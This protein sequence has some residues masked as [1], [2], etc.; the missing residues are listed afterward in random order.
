MG[1][2]ELV[3]QARLAHA[4]LAHERHHLPVPG[5]GALQDVAQLVDFGVAADEAREPPRRGCLES[6]PRRPRSHE[7]VDLDLLPQPFDGR[8]A[9]RVDLHVPLAK[10]EGVSRDERGARARQLLH[11]GRQVRGLAHRGVVHVEVAP[12]GAHDDLAGVQTD[13]DLDVEAL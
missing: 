12:D 7:L 5:T 1:V 13:P 2:G 11:A 6:G 4:C 9:K 8:R 3:E 10:P